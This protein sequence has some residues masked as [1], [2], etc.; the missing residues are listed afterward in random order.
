MTEVTDIFK[1]LFNPWQQRCRI[2]PVCENLAVIEVGLPVEGGK[3]RQH[4][5]KGIQMNNANGVATDKRHH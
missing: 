2:R 5:A 3:A 4:F 1:R